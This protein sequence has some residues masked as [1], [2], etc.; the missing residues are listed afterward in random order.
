MDEVLTWRQQADKALEDY[1]SPPE[2]LNDGYATLLDYAKACALM[3]IAESLEIIAAA[4][5]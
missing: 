2:P 4:A 3:S 1:G 5:S